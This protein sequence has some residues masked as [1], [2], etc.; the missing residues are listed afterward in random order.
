MYGSYHTDLFA[1]GAAQRIADGLSDLRV[2]FSTGTDLMPIVEVD[3]LRLDLKFVI[4]QRQ[5]GDLS[6]DPFCVL[7]ILAAAFFPAISTVLLKNTEE[8]RKKE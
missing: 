3:H 7:V 5:C 1:P 8:E 4:R 6:V 2:Q